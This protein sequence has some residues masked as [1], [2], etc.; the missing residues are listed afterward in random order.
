[1]QFFRDDARIS[2]TRD[3]GRIFYSKLVVEI[4]LCEVESC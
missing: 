1:M 4:L 2:N 3:R